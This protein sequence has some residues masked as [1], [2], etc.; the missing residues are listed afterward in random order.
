MGNVTFDFG[1]IERLAEASGR[2]KAA[3]EL[4]RTSPFDAVHL[5]AGGRGFWARCRGLTNGYDVWAGPPVGDYFE[6]GCTCLTA[7]HPCKHAVALLLYLAANPAARPGDPAPPRVATADFEALVRN[8]FENPD[9]DLARLV[10]ADYLEE[11]GDGDRA[12]F[13]RLQ[14]EYA[15]QTRAAAEGVSGSPKRLR[16]MGPKASR[17]QVELSRKLFPDGIGFASCYLNVD[18]GFLSFG[19]LS[20]DLPD[21][22]SLPMPVRSY[23]E[24]AW[25]VRALVPHTARL[26]TDESA[27][28]YRRA[29]VIDLSTRTRSVRFLTAAARALRPGAPDSRVCHVLVTPN[30]AE[31]WRMV[32]AKA[33]AAGKSPRPPR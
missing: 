21:W 3:K 33:A 9:N 4:L 15:G 18:R 29:G 27:A 7:T 17:R 2:L 14:I 12:E 10:L 30:N 25:V 20:R 23:F 26:F 1:A 8:V 5:T 6:S 28:L 16:K 22:Q 31:A 11:Q 13:I 24:A 19:T 32:S